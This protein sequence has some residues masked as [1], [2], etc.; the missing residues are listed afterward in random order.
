M[1]LLY[2][3]FN[4]TIL[5]PDCVFVFGDNE[6]AIHGAGAAKTALKWGAKHGQHGLV[7]QTYGI[8]TKSAKFETLP[9]SKIQE[10]VDKFI[11]FTKT[12]P[13]LKFYV[14]KIGCGLAGYTEEEIAPLF[15][16]AIGL[17]NIYLPAEFNNILS[18]PFLDD[19]LVIKRLTNEYK[20]HK[21][22]IIAV[23]FDSTLYPWP[24]TEKTKYVRVLNL[25]K[26][27]QKLGFYIV[28]YTA[29]NE[30]RYPFMV[31]YLQK[32]GIT[33]SSVNKNPIDLPFGNGGK[34]YYNILLCDRAG[35]SSA[36]NV[37][38]TV[39]YNIEQENIS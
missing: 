27:C 24:V 17:S 9:L 13:D 32:Q 12:R 28:V 22:L 23:D 29:S 18:D 6:A 14:T 20:K 7:G 16:D 33:V 31:D 21:K 36:Y 25:I 4:I 26:R 37:L 35:L 3:P 34:I 5:N 30:E 39:V 38:N 15:Y 8:A 19:D 10:Y 2:S 1:N 11:A